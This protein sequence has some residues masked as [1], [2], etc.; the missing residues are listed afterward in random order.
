MTEDQIE[1]AVERLIDSLDQQF[2]TSNMTQAAY[3]AAMREIDQWAEQ[4]L[5]RRT[6]A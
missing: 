6:A 2:L 3:D 4:Q 1:R 5:A